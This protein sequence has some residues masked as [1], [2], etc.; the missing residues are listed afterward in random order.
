MALISRRSD[1]FKTLDAIKSKRIIM[2]HDFLYNLA[3]A[4]GMTNIIPTNSI[5]DGLRMLSDKKAD[6]M[7]AN[8]YTCRY[9]MEHKDIKNLTCIHLHSRLLAIALLSRLAIPNCS[10]PSMKRL[11]HDV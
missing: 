10:I 8:E 9:L 1:D 6:A 5:E 4:S 7:I 11:I 2:K 3:V